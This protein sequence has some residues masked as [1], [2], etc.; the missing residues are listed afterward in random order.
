MNIRLFYFILSTITLSVLFQRCANPG[1]VSGG[2]KDTIPPT[3]I[4][5][6]PEDQ[7]LNFKGQTITLT[8]DEFINADKIHQNLIISPT[9]TNKFKH[10]IK[11]RTITLKFEDPLLDS[12]TYTFNF[13][14]AIT[15]ITEKSSH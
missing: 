9:T 13:F 11:K 2:P 8:F 15:D 1:F 5:M 10:V 14:D 6:I 3:A 12:T 4:S 7:T